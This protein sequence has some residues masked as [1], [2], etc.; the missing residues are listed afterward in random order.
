[1][2]ENFTEPRTIF[3]QLF[4]FHNI[5]ETFT[6]THTGRHEILQRGHVVWF[7]FQLQIYLRGLLWPYPVRT[8]LYETV[9]C[10]TLLVMEMSDP[11]TTFP[12]PSKIY[13]IIEKVM[14]ACGCVCISVYACECSFNYSKK[15]TINWKLKNHLKTGRT[16]K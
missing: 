2:S 5:M 11:R 4:T 15:H 9:A 8:L 10:L 1:M 6:N 7:V 12:S 16:I 3:K 13:I 14:C